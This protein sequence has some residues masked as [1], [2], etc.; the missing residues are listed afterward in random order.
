MI[1]DVRLI[2]KLYEKRRLDVDEYMR[3]EKHRNAIK[4]GYYRY[5]KAISRKR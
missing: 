4:F 2:L 5:V 3:K 1:E